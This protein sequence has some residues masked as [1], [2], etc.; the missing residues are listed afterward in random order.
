M[1]LRVYVSEGKKNEWKTEP[2]KEKQGAVFF[3]FS[4]VHTF[5]H[6]SALLPSSQVEGQ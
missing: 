5:I 6:A 3:V 2:K 4:L 1:E